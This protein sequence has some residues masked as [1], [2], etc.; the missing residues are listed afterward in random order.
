MATNT[1]PRGWSSSDE[2][3]RS[4]S[5]KSLIFRYFGPCLIDRINPGHSQNSNRRFYI[6]NNKR[7]VVVE[8][9]PFI[10]NSRRVSR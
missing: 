3:E 9:I 7:V 6:T 4:S 8:V 2:R 1:T 10:Y 5:V